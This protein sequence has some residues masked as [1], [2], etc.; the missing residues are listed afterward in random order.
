MK[1]P[2]DLSSAKRT[3]H[4]G[5][6][7][8]FLYWLVGF[9][10]SGFDGDVSERE[11][12]RIRAKQIGAVTRLVPVTMTDQSCQCRDHPFRLLEFR[13]Q[14]F[15]RR[16]GVGDRRSRRYGDAVVGTVAAQAARRS[17]AQCHQADDGSGL[18]SWR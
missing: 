4:N 5:P 18:A 17:F 13:F 3:A 12:R 15:P 11:M 6:L 1:W 2:G 14:P 10:A 8:A 7:G 16:V 9:S